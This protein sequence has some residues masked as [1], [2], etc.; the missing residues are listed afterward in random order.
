[1][2]TRSK[3]AI[4]TLYL[5]YVF[6]KDNYK[7]DAHIYLFKALR[8]LFGDGYSTYYNPLTIYLPTTSDFVEVD[9]AIAQEFDKYPALKG[10]RFQLQMCQD[11]SIVQ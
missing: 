8:S 10:M 7:N 3:F 9:A 2:S 1:M 4:G 5:K 11:M 6:T